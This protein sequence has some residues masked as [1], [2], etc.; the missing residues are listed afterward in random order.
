M[1]QAKTLS[2][3]KLGILVGDGGSPET[4]SSDC[5][6]N[7]GDRGIGF[8]SDTNDVI[9]PDCTNPND[10]AWKQV[11]KDGFKAEI[12]GSGVL[13]TDKNKEWFNWFNSDTGKNCRVEFTGVA[14]A[15]G[16]GYWEGQFKLTSYNV[17]G[18]RGD[19][20]QVEFTLESNSAITWTD[21][22]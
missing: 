5:L 10:P 9:V 21:A 19:L 13:P 4:F 20:V 16:G 11:M 14:G 2:G 8:T 15:D 3:V 6:A 12:T 22:A 1:A 7:T 18:S 17:S